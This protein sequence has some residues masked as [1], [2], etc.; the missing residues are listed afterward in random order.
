MRLA[1]LCNVYPAVSH[2]F[3]RREIEAVERAG[4]KVFRFSIRPIHE[5]I[6]DPA[7][8]REATVT[9][10]VLEQGWP[11]L[12]LATT[13]LAISRP[14]RA[15]AAVRKALRL[16]GKGVAEKA[17]HLIYLMEAAWLAQRFAELRV[18]HLHAH[19]GT[20]PAAVAAIAHSWSGTPFSFTIHGPDEF[21]APVQL[22]L[23]EKAAEATLVATISDYCRS[24][25][26][27]WIPERNWPKIQVVRCGLD[28]DFLNEVPAARH[29][30]S[31]QLLTVARLSQQ[32]GLPL[33]IDACSKL[34]DDGVHF[35]L[36]I[37]GYGDMRRELEEKI[38]EL[39]LEQRV[40][41]AGIRS[42]DEIRELLRE[43]RV[44]V[45]PSFAEGLPVVLMEALAL[46]TPVIATSIAGIPELV[47]DGCGWLI[48]AGSETALVGA[49]KKALEATP[50]ELNA[51]GALGRER[52]LKLHDV[53]RNALS[54][55]RSIKN[56]TESGAVDPR[57]Q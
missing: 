57:S 28:R 10:V 36:T 47:D 38:R 56:G 46:G 30:D 8:L 24:Q 21:D 19:F 29:G 43:A 44:F 26:M 50:G 15:G 45:L 33:L 7:D 9:T 55:L 11:A 20:N 16:S 22:R 41:L 2:S 49:I 34:R 31:V 13:R 37:V 12:T 52:V 27:R 42:S 32:K 23:K 18:D 51:K 48:P 1:Y 17:R 14:R 54:L 39:K 53:D 6:T 4:H 3:V 40:T 5:G 35:H 25:L